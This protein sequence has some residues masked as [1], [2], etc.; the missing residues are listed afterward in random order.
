MVDAAD[1]TAEAR[2]AQAM[3]REEREQRIAE[4]RDANAEAEAR[5]EERRRDRE[6][7][8]LDHMIVADARETQD[9]NDLHHGEP[10][11]APPMR[12]A[13]SSGVIYRD[14]RGGEPTPAPADALAAFN[15][16]GGNL[17]D[18]SKG[19]VKFVCTVIDEE[20][21]RARK[22][23]AAERASEQSER[24]AE[25][26]KFQIEIDDLRGRISDVL[27]D[28][29]A[30]LDETSKAL[31]T[32]AADVVRENRDRQALFNTLESHFH[33]LKAFVR[34]TVKDWSAM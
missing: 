3:T 19:V 33:E 6:E 13:A 21:A 10:V 9:S 2:R 11:G 31:S 28:V 22:E 15:G 4:L 29:S 16:D 18:Y 27:R 7:N 24:N 14:Y 25:L 5:I 12:S 26:A 23:R 30:R 1:T 20:R 8:P 32:L 34:G 17:D